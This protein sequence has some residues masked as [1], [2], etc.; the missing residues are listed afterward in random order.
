MG[1][2]R[3]GSTQIKSRYL[4]ILVVGDGAVPFERIESELQRSGLDFAIALASDER[5]LLEACRVCPPDVVVAVDSEDTFDA[6][7][8]L[9]LCREVCAD[10]P[11]IVIAS[12][13]SEEVVVEALRSGVTDYVVADRLSR[14]GPALERAVRDHEAERERRV[15]EE[16]VRIAEQRFR[17]VFENAPVGIA[18]RI[19]GRPLMA[20]Q[21]YA[22]ILGLPE[23]RPS[24]S[25]EFLNHVAPEYRALL[26]GA[27]SGADP[28]AAAF[29]GA[30]IRG[31][32]SR[33]SYELRVTRMMLGT[34]PA[35]VAFVSDITERKAAE[36]ELDSYRADLERMVRERTEELM[37][38]NRRLQ[39]ATQTRIRFLSSMSHEL[40]TPL[41]SVIGFSGVL[42]QGM[43]GPLTEDQRRQLEIIYESGKR[44][45]STI[46][47]VLDVSRIEAGKAEVRWEQ[48]ELDTALEALVDSMRPDAQR[49][50]LD[51][52][53]TLPPERGQIVSDRH[54]LTQAVRGLLENAIKFTESGGV[55]LVLERDESNVRIRVS[56]TGVGIPA[57]ELPHVFDEFR[58]VRRPDGVRPEGAGLGLSL[59]GKLAGLLGGAISCTSEPDAGSEF[60]LEFPVGPVVHLGG[61]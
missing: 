57:D 21:E 32:G 37:A 31:D 5:E 28:V 19:A 51:L 46:D 20:N 10:A 40:R 22:R 59:C 23:D 43:S 49:R 50:G 16:A 4:D 58:Q 53:L 18:I 27:H 26:T 52:V 24:D 54:K 33:F 29:E 44:L 55:T 30:A 11:L 15:A 1:R 35:T 42:L 8:T 17:S 25:D 36:S 60:V 12:E 38:A 41:N 3:L 9:A 56:D 7:A 13:A 6:V 39:E 2:I 61:A 14:L 48:F 34:E 47:D 45:M